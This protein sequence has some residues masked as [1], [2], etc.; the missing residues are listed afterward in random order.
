MS[1]KDRFALAVATCGVGYIK[2]APGT[3]GSLVGVLLY[4]IWSVLVGALDLN[5]YSGGAVTAVSFVV[6]GG[7]VGLVV[8]VGIWA[9]GQAAKLFGEKDPQKIVVDEVMGQLV[10]YLFIPFG[11]GW[12]LL[13]AGFVLFRLFD[14]FKPYPIRRFETLPGGFGVC[15]DD[16]AAGVYAGLVLFVANLLLMNPA[17][18]IF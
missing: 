4:L 6:N 10:T 13:L 15:I 16:I 3:W 2:Y 17:S 1:G 11:S 7:A 18:P 5:G 14:I 8:A 9:A 12:R